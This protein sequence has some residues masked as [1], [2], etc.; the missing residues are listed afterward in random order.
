M[1]GLLAGL[2]AWPLSVAAA[3]E[4]LAAVWGNTTAACLETGGNV[5][6]THAGSVLLA[7]LLVLGLLALLAWCLKRWPR[8]KTLSP[9][10]SG[11]LRMINRFNASQ[12]FLLWE[13]AGKTYALIVKNSRVEMMVE[14]PGWRWDKGEGLSRKQQPRTFQAIWMNLLKSGRKA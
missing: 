7:L 5:P 14:L 2:G 12:T 6:E 13:E 11:R 10:D 1:G 9:T 8:L 4:P 3:E